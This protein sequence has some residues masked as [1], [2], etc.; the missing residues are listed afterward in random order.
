MRRAMVTALN[1][2]NT[3]TQIYKKV[4]EY[5][6]KISLNNVCTY[7]SLLKKEGIVTCI[8]ESQSKG[9]LYKLTPDGVR[10]KEQMQKSLFLLQLYLQITLL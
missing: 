2:E 3:P 10:I 8:N 1:R 9:R 4:K 6:S 5:N 7:L